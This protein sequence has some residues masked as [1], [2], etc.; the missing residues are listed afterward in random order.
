MPKKAKELSAKAVEKLS[1]DGAH[2]VG[3]V[4]GLLLQ[5]RGDSARSWVLRIRI[6]EKR[7]TIGLGAYPELSLAEA[8]RKAQAMRVSV[9]NGGDPL[10]DKRDRR[11]SLADSNVLTFDE[12]ARRLIAAK[13]PEW[14]NA[15]HAAQWARTLETYASPCIGKIPVADVTTAH[16]VEVLTPIW[17]T[18]TETASRV[19]QRI[20]AVLDWAKAYGARDGDNPARWRGH[21]DKLMA[22]PSK[23]REVRHHTAL[24][25]DAMHGF[26]LTLRAREGMAA[27]ALELAI[28]TA[29]R[30][31]EV[32]GAT[33]AEIDLD[34]ATWTVPAERM[35]A[36]KE[37]RVPLSAPAIALLRALPRFAGTELVFPNSKGQPL[38]D[39]ALLSVMK[40]MQVDAVP[41][42]FRSTFRDWAG[43]RTNYPRDV[44]E[45]AL[46]HTLRDK[47]EASYRRGDALAKRATMMA[48]W[49]TF[50]DTAPAVGNVTPIRRQA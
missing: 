11:A 15:K 2:A 40:R 3:G 46:A 19:R 6:N 26:M 29:A 49:A 28:L 41:H 36:R 30:S 21:L 20:E 5:I 31:G 44:A 34:S 43:D 9:S 18:K 8:R 32:R 16:V 22:T 38:S 1:K 39:M 4:D 45:M 37:H 7:R 50:I 10:Q 23:V 12:A 17:R 25:V 42:G 48:D 47:V 27:R 13:S 24:P 35:K 33:W 14:A